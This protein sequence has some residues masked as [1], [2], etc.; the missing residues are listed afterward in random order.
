MFEYG[1]INVPVEPDTLEADAGD[2]QGTRVVQLIDLIYVLGR[3]ILA[4]GYGFLDKVVGSLPNKL[5]GAL[6]GVYG[7]RTSVDNST[8]SL[9]V[10]SSKRKD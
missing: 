9:T 3:D 1:F 6:R 4:P 5:N 7:G 8:H 2:L 10:K